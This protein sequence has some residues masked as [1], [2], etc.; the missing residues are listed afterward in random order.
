MIL[1]PSLNPKFAAFRFSSQGVRGA[2][3]RGASQKK[4]GISMSMKNPE[5]S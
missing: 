3:G 2:E 4:R 5:Q 1:L